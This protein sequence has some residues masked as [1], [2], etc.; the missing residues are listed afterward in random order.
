MSEKTESLTV[1]AAHS[2]ARVR[3]LRVIKTPV[4]HELPLKPRVLKSAIPSGA[5]IIPDCSAS[6]NLVHSAGE[7]HQA[8]GTKTASIGKPT[9]PL[10]ENVATV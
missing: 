8:F 2:F 4:S 6:P 5:C 1:S 3:L 7:Q 9:H 10:V